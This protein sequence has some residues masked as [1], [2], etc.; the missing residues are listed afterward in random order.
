MLFMSECMYFWCAIFIMHADWLKWSSNGQK[1]VKAKPK[2][3]ADFM[4]L[5][6]QQI[7]NKNRRICYHGYCNDKGN[8]KHLW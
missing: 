4:I 5:Y 6:K 3:R 1:Y 8:I 2:I 7:S